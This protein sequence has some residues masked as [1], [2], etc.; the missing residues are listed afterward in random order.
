MRPLDAVLSKLP[1]ARNRGRYF[2]ARCPGHDD[3]RPSLSISEGP[4]GRVLLK[5]FAG[6]PVDHIV[7]RLGLRMRD[8]FVRR[9]R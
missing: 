3:A 6:C 2:S 5:C 9:A 8:L 4:D 1:E 7:G